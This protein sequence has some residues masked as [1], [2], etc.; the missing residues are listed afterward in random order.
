MYVYI[1][2]AELTFT[3]SSSAG[4]MELDEL[5]FFGELV[6]LRRPPDSWD[7]GDV[8]S[9]EPVP[10]LDCFQET[11]GFYPVDCFAY[12]AYC[13]KVAGTGGTWG[14]SS[15]PE[16]SLAAAQDV[17]EPCKVELPSLA[18][19][20]LTTAAVQ[21]R[22]KRPEGMPSKN[23]MAER[24]RRKRLND[25]LSMLRSVVPNISK[26]DRT[27]ILGDTIDYVRELLEKIKKLQEE[28]EVGGFDKANLLG[29]FQELN[30]GVILAKNSPKF[31]VKRLNA[32]TRIDMYCSSKPGMLLSTVSTLESLGLEIQHCVVSCFNDFG[33]QA[34]CTENMEQR[35]V[36]SSEDIKK[37]L[38]SSSGIVGSCL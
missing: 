13:Q 9:G 28:T 8:F 21:E 34:S 27:S 23:L 25:R 35:A 18:E 19:V 17:M 15:M 37:A 10:S 32:D 22:K 26:M 20:S 12:D 3:F 5:A 30:P 14:Y 36:I 31:E 6:A 1:S 24:R 38:F 33:M 16:I 11:G 2:R 29:L 4:L 7:S